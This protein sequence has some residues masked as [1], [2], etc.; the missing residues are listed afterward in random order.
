MS[1]S[2]TASSSAGFAR[3][4]TPSLSFAI[5]ILTLSA[6]SASSSTS[7]FSVRVRLFG[8]CC[9]I[10][11]RLVWSVGGVSIVTFGI[12][13]VIVVGICA[14][15]LLFIVSSSQR[16]SFCRCTSVFHRSLIRIID[17]NIRFL[18]IFLF[19][20]YFFY[21][22]SHSI[23]PLILGLLVLLHNF[24]LIPGLGLA[25][26]G[27]V[28]RR[29]GSCI[30]PR[31]GTRGEF[32]R[33]TLSGTSTCITTSAHPSLYAATATAATNVATVAGRAITALHDSSGGDASRSHVTIA[34]AGIAASHELGPVNPWRGGTSH[35]ALI[36]VL[37]PSAAHGS[38]YISI[39]AAMASAPEAVPYIAPSTISVAAAPI[40]APMP[41]IPPSATSLLSRRHIDLDGST[42]ELWIF[43]VKERHELLRTLEFYV[44]IPPTLPRVPFQHQSCRA[45]S[46]RPQRPPRPLV[47]HLHPPTLQ[48]PLDLGTQIAGIAHVVAKVAQKG[49]V[50]RPRRKYEFLLEGQF[51]LLA[52]FFFLVFR[53]LV[54]RGRTGQARGRGGDAFV[55][56]FLVGGAMVCP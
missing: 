3:A 26:N 52:L 51:L 48:Q 15:I 18:L 37:T 2:A 35:A 22:R 25:K 30:L 7:I 21:A 42:T 50:G 24:C 40:L 41:A 8:C 27:T 4:V 55:V 13:L 44:P 11:S 38:P 9:F 36:R 12:L 56:R 23:D 39:T 49:R 43:H 6:P 32:E 53:E 10:S 20:L 29:S 34:A 1:P 17:C 19:Y 14:L 54:V 16:S 46:H 28:R 45:Q 33:G 5:A 31:L 47:H